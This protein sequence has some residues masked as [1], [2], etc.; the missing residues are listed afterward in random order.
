M[1]GSCARAPVP[2]LLCQSF[3]A[4]QPAAMAARIQCNLHDV[5]QVFQFSGCLEIQYACTVLRSAPD[6]YASG[7][8]RSLLQRQPA[9]RLL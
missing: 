7:A 8:E 2:E 3:F 6:L 5:Q 1:L 4:A 9:A